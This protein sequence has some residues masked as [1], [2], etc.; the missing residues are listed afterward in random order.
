MTSYDMV[1]WIETAQADLRQELLK[2][3]NMLPLEPDHEG[4]QVRSHLTFSI[5]LSIYG[6]YFI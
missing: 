1:C 5:A 3:L 6:D 2:T 4:G